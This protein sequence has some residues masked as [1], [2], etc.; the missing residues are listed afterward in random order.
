MWGFG[1]TG[2]NSFSIGFTI[3]EKVSKEEQHEIFLFDLKF[4]PFLYLSKSFKITTSKR[5]YNFNTNI[6]KKS[7]SVLSSMIDSD[8]NYSEFKFNNSD[9]YNTMEKIENLY[10]GKKVIIYKYEYSF[11]Q[12]FVD[13][14]KINNFPSFDRENEKFVLSI[15][16]YSFISFF[17]CNYLIYKISTK[18]DIY[19]C[20]TIGIKSSRVC[21]MTFALN[22]TYDFPDE[23]NEFS[24]IRDFFNFQPIKITTQNVAVLKKISEDLKINCLLEK[25]NEFNNY[26]EF[27]VQCLNNKKER[28]E[29]VEE[30]FQYLFNR[31][32][33]SAESVKDKLVDSIWS[34]SED[35]VKEMV[36]CIIH[37]INIDTRLH[38]FLMSLIELLDNSK[39]DD[40]DLKLLI[41]F[42]VQKLMNDIGSSMTNC[43]FIYKLSQ[44][45]FI[46]REEI[47]EVIYRRLSFEDESLQKD[48]DLEPFNFVNKYLIK[49]EKKFDFDSRN[50]ALLW[51]CPELMEIKHMQLDIIRRKINSV[52]NNAFFS[53]YFPSDPSKFKEM[54]DS[55]EPDDKLTLAIRHDDVDELKSSLTDSPNISQ[56]V[57]FNLFESFVNNGRTNLLNYAAAYGSIKCFKYLLDNKAEILNNTFTYAVFGENK[58]IMELVNQS[59]QAQQPSTW[60]GSSSSRSTNINLT[61]VLKTSTDNGFSR[62]I[63]PKLSIET[64]GKFNNSVFSRQ[65]SSSFS[66]GSNV[67]HP[68]VP[69][70]M[71]HNDDLFKCILVNTCNSS[72]FDDTKLFLFLF[73]ECNISL[74]DFLI[75]SG[76]YMNILTNKE[77]MDIIKVSARSGFYTLTELIF[78]LV[79]NVYKRAL[80]NNP[81]EVVDFEDSVS[82]GN[83]SI[84]KLY[85]SLNINDLYF[86]DI[87][88][89]SLIHEDT[90]II[91]YSLMY[92]FIQHYHFSIEDVKDLIKQINI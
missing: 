65:E 16:N 73:E 56:I 58:E 77:I 4:D 41:P 36:A 54:R 34:H 62:F 17:R 9:D 74:I 48:K 51:F 33:S 76:L 57:P 28:I 13:I 12:T 78:S 55:G 86:K 67:I 19:S 68:L 91:E 82:F 3:N 5:S 59:F 20:S 24:T 38:P 85:A 52:I 50:N 60:W 66:F 89:I 30:L 72:N 39:S 27:S 25:I 8:S 10:S 11:L 37:V 44:K 46:S 21:N 79:F 69:T 2:P 6:I 32:H 31:Q 7:S 18:K 40:N 43:A 1:F 80:I 61:K 49:I 45:G 14:L 75:K 64:S 53:K 23:N 81:L 88:A 42:L 71:K 70:I 47:A 90:S 83:L 63:L 22:Y 15:S 29:K 92:P 87:F 35:N 84:F 26:Y